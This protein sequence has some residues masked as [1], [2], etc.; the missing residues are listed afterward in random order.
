M[1]DISTAFKEC[2]ETLNAISQKMGN[3][4]YPVIARNS[5]IIRNNS[6]CEIRL[7]RF[8]GDYATSHLYTGW[9]LS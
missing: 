7:S 3:A 5:S 4:S 8:I 9:L 6:T 1:N 2:L